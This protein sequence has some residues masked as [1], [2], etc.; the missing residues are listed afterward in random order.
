MKKTI[1]D[2]GDISG[3]R[4][5]VRVD[6][7]VP[8]DDDGNITDTTRIERSLPTIKYLLSQGARLVLCSHLGRPKGEKKESLSLLPVAKELMNLLPLTK[9]KFSFQTIGEK[10]EQATHELKNGE[11]LLLENVRFHKEEEKNDPLF[12]KKL[13]RLADIYVNDAFG[14]AHRK[15][16]ST[17]GVARLLPN[18]MGFLMGREVNTILNVLENAKRPFVA[19]LGGAKVADKIY[20]VLNM[21]KRVDIMIIGG[22]MAYTFLA[23]KGYK[24]G[25]SLV[26]EDKIDLARE[27]LEE[28]ERSKIPVILPVDHKCGTSFSG[29]VKEQIVRKPDIPDHLIGMDLGPKTIKIFKKY[30]RRARTIIWNGP[31][32]VFEF[33]NFSEGTEEIAKA[34]AKVKGVSIVGGGD[35]VASIRLLD[36]EE[37]ITH[38]STGGGASIKLLEGELLPGIEVIENRNK[39]VKVAAPEKKKR[40]NLKKDEKIKNPY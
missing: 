37:Q 14:T 31:M 20:V 19:V 22:G 18:A 38:I 11:I 23:A 4:V 30:I 3:K 10:V 39:L 25:G 21:L 40:S 35:S 1:E 29:A 26:E 15:H 36:L 17:A 5:L 2:L 9:I 12:A 8:L 33:D 13:A 32:G 6:F 34:V 16:A 27:I 24:V 28:A 7:N